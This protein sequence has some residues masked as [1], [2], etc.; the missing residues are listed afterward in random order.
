MIAYGGGKM[1]QP[2]ITRALEL[3]PNVNFTNAYGLTETSSTITLLTPD[4]PRWD[5][6]TGS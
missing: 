6:C 3:F 4:D 5:A 2:V 1:T